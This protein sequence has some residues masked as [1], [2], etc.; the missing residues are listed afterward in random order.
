MLIKL[1]H[2]TINTNDFEKSIS[3]VQKQG[4]ILDVCYKNIENPKIKEKFLENYYPLHHLALLKKND[5]LDIEIIDQKSTNHSNSFIKNIICKEKCIKISILTSSIEKSRWFWEKLG[6]SFNNTNT[7]KFQSVLNE[8]LIHIELIVDRQ[9]EVESLHGHQGSYAIAFIS[10]H[11]IKEHL[12]LQQANIQVSDI[13]I[14]RL[15]NQMLKIFFAFGEQGELV[16][17]YQIIN[18]E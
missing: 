11:L 4:Y 15:G 10:N 7:L 9:Y 1:A 6:F 17:I 8:N 14:L 12:R 16:E 5:C 2:V 13:E 3:D 18:Q